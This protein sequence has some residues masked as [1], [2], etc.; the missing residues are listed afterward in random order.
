L[1]Q[2]WPAFRFVRGS[3]K[4]SSNAG[5]VSTHAL[6][7]QLDPGNVSALTPVIES[8]IGKGQ[9]GPVEAVSIRQDGLLHPALADAGTAGDLYTPF[10]T[11]AT[12]DRFVDLPRLA[13]FQGTTDRSWLG[14]CAELARAA[15]R[16]GARQPGQ[17]GMLPALR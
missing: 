4:H 7:T 2:N 5:F 15:D 13:I 14:A 11:A 6:V 1:P 8:M 12:P 9:F 17:R 3:P 16:V 10:A